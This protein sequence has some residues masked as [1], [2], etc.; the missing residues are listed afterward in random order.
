MQY[1]LNVTVAILRV[2]QVAA[3]PV[4]EFLYYIPI[5]C[6]ISSRLSIVQQNHATRAWP[7]DGRCCKDSS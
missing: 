3:R 2:V 7:S 4:L 5:V 1:V 6:T